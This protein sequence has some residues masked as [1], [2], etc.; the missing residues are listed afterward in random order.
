M[1]MVSDNLKVAI[2]TGHIPLSDVSKTLTSELFKK[3]LNM[4]ESS[5]IND[6][7]ITKPKI[8]IKD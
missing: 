6:F 4:L 5:L 2:V 7:G 1:M 8:A 3:K